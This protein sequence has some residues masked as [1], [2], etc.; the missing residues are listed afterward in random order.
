MGAIAAFHTHR[1]ADVGGA[2]FDKDDR[3]SAELVAAATSLRCAGHAIPPPSFFDA[4]GAAGNIVHAVAT[5]NAI[6][7][8]LVS[9]EALKLVAR[10]A[11][12]QLRATFLFAAPSAGRLLTAGPPPPPA[13]GCA[14]C[15]TAG[16]RV[17]LDCGVVTLGELVNKVR[18]RERAGRERGVG[19]EKSNNDAPPP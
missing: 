19:R 4:R 1:T 13:P 3:L 16:V 18:R 17:S 14:V 5:T 9:V 2:T 15:G 7:A 11:A 6:V 10:V 8:G 12:S